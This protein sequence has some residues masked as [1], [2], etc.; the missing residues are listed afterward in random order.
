MNGK[1][2]KLVKFD[3]TTGNWEYKSISI[4][5]AFNDFGSIGIEVEAPIE[6]R[7]GDGVPDDEDDYPDD[8]DRAFKSYYPGANTYGTLAY[9]DLWPAKGDYDF[10]DLVLK[11]QLHT[12]LNA[13]N[14]A[15]AFEGTFH[16]KHIGASFENGF[17]FNFDIPAS[18]VSTMTGTRLTNGY[19]NTDG[20]FTEMN[21]E[22]AT[23]ILFDNANSQLYD[24][25]NVLVSFTEPIE[26]NDLGEYPFNPFIIIDKNRDYEVHLPD[27]NNTTLADVTLFGTIDDSSDANSN[28]YY[29]TD[30]NLPWATDVPHYFVWP[31]EKVE[32]IKKYK[33]IAEWA[34][35]GG[36]VYDDWY[37]DNDGYRDEEFLDID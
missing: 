5:A 18:K 4:K 37:L 8:P 10:N 22:K 21:N 24:T 20:N 1:N 27:Q 35:S 32:I 19:I 31:K 25:I 23:V 3:I 7:D 12:I 14:K 28:R 34:E 15:V 30:R 13:D 16:V 11:Y 2:D 29:K 33:K 26:T 36:V 6:D 17:G 9:E